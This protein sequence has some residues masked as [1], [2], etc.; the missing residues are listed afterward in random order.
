MRRG[1]LHSCL[2]WLS[3]S[4][5]APMLAQISPEQTEFFEKKIRPVLAEK[6]YACHGPNLAKPTSNRNTEPRTPPSA[7]RGD[8][9]ISVFT[10]WS[11]RGA[12]DPRA[13]AAAAPA[14]K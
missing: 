13:D 1:F 14:K 5:A 8:Q 4:M 3:L 2:L 6:R 9:Q 10:K 12:P 7:R 11:K